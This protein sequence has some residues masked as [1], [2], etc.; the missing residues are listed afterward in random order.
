MDA[1]RK[2][3]QREILQQADV[4]IK[5]SAQW[6]L[7]IERVK[8]P[9]TT[10][11][12][13]TMDILMKMILLTVQKLDVSQPKKIAEFLAV[14]PLFVEDL[15]ERMQVTEMIEYRRRAFRLTKVGIA[16]LQSGIYEHPPERQEKGFFYSSTHDALWCP[17]RLEWEEETPF[18]LATKRKNGAESVSQESLRTALL[19][20]GVEEAE[21][22]LQVVIDKIEKPITQ[23]DQLVPCL[24]FYVY[25][26]TEDSYYTRV[27]NTLLERWDERLETLID[28]LDPLL[29]Q[30]KKQ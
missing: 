5:Q 19:Q 29:K 15:C 6:G 27:W 2:K 18:R 20:A 10:I 21:G 11:K 30:S 4:E 25:S 9:C 28:E 3:L 16:Q 23:D 13:T 1:L 26:R 7:P 12:R 17:A 14:E 22:S 8:I 24:E